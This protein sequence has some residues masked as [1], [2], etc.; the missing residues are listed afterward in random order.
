MFA[1]KVTTGGWVTAEMLA[2]GIEAQATI[3]DMFR[4]KLAKWVNSQGYALL[5]GVRIIFRKPSP[6]E[7]PI[8]KD[9]LR[10]RAVGRAVKVTRLPQVF[11][12]GA[13][14]LC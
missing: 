10:V 8:L 11:S 4:E 12:Q 5:P 1:E 14:N 6:D 13:I 3:A 2:D 9:A 7:V